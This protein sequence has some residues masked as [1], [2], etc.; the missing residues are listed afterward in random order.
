MKR[1]FIICSIVTILLSCNNA[2]KHKTEQIGEETITQVSGE[3]Q[4]MNE[5]MEKARSTFSEF[6]KAFIENQTSDKYHSFTIK[7]GF[8]SSKYGKEHMWLG[9][10]KLDSDKFTGILFNTPVDPEVK[11]KQGDTIVVDPVQVSD[12]MYVDAATGITKGGYTFIAMRKNMSPEEQAEFDEQT[13]LKF[14]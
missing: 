12:W 5:A 3:D 14:E 2:Q 1:I 7:I 4:E 10:L 8:D 9:D 11:Q 13:G 6:K